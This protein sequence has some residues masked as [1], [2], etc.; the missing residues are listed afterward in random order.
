MDWKK[1]AETEKHDS[2]QRRQESMN[3]APK[4]KTQALRN[5]SVPRPKDKVTVPPPSPQDEFVKR[6][7]TFPPPV[8][9]SVP[10]PPIQRSSKYPRYG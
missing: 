10:R 9:M 2:W 6:K 7:V 4:A 3:S 1:E 8:P 5:K